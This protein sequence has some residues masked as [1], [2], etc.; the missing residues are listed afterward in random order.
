MN[1]LLLALALSA[2]DS[3][4][5]FYADK[6][7]LMVYMDEAGTPQPVKTP[8]DWERRKAHVL[9][10]MQLV[11]GPMPTA[12]RKVPLDIRVEEEK[13][14]PKYLRKK[15]SFAV[16]DWDRLDAYLCIPK[17]LTGKTAGVVCL[18]PTY[19]HGKDIAV[20]ISGKSHRNYGE[21]LAMRGYVTISPDYPGFGEAVD[22]RAKAYAKG[23]VSITMKGIWNHM[24]CVDLLQSLA[25]VDPE[26][27]A[28]VGHSLGGHN[29]L[30]LGTFDERVNVMVTSCGFNTFAKYK[31]GDL[32]GWSH[33]GYMPRIASE[34]GKDPA[35]MPFDFTEVLGVLAPRAV[36]I[37][38]PLHDANFEV[39]GVR[40]CMAAAAPVFALHGAQKR[41]AVIYPDAD[42]DF[43]DAARARAYA[44]IESMLGAE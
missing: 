43:P 16:E 42:H 35:R 6:M 38:A 20:G 29:T 8:E 21:E 37:N 17:K 36:F 41:L 34:Y 19:E 12:S 15:I 3:P 23:Y 24:R 7:N 22:L 31:E 13:D 28:A 25:E 40:D 1:A 9:A 11:M 14:F 30:Y 26:R 2:A 27:I 39:S 32:T 10:N 44:F 18:H 5:P 4:P 33:D